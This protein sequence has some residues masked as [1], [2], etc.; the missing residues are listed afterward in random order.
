LACG[1]S[2]PDR[3]AEGLDLASQPLSDYSLLRLPRGGGEAG[4]YA[5]PGLGRLAWRSRSRL[6]RLSSTAGADLDQHVAFALAADGGVIALDLQTGAVRTVLPETRR[7]V[8][9]AD[10]TLWAVDGDGAVSAVTRRV[11]RA[12]P[13][14][15][16][17]PGALFGTAAGQLVAVGE[18]AAPRAILLGAGEAGTTAD[19]PAGRVAA[20][21]LGDVVAV[22]ADTALV[23]WHPVGGEVN[24]LPFRLGAADVAFS[25]AGH[26]AYVLTDGPRLDIVEPESREIA[27][28]VD[29]PGAGGAIRTDPLG[30]WLLVRSAAG[31][32]IWVVDPVAREVAGM[33]RADWDA[34]LPAVVGARVVLARQGGDVVALSLDDAALPEVGRVKGGAT[35]YWLPLAWTPRAAR[36]ATEELQPS[37]AVERREAA[38]AADSDAEVVAPAERTLYLQLSSSQNAAWAADLAQQLRR[39]GVEASVLAADS[40]GGLHRVVTGP[41]A[42]REEAEEVARG[43]GRPS[44]I[45]RPGTA[46][47]DQEAV[48]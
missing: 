12:V 18:Q 36:V 10:R 4:L 3:P 38:E 13:G 24:S 28:S 37:P 45:F 31:G 17:A 40:V 20:T 9:G 23:F 30:A 15:A 32:E 7:A 47:P 29:L 39:A 2:A 46:A 5:I 48:P 34:D 33:F 25:P 27:G 16:P 11:V 22:A 21:D 1:G 35:D 43:L 19:L 42:T 14:R 8:L 44:F 6:P 26:R 41:Y